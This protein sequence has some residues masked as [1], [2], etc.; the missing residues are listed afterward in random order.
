MLESQHGQCGFLSLRK[1]PVD[2]G[3]LR[4]MADFTW[5]ELVL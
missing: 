3:S 1:Q 2:Q 4:P 5:S